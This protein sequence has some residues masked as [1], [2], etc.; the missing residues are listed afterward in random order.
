MAERK[1]DDDY[2]VESV[3]ATVGTHHI[4]LNVVIKKSTHQKFVAFVVDGTL[5]GCS[6]GIPPEK[7]Y[8]LHEWIIIDGQLKHI[9]GISPPVKHGLKQGIQILLENQ[10]L[11]GNERITAMPGQN[12]RIVSARKERLDLVYEMWIF[13]SIM[14]PVCVV[15]VKVFF[16]EI[17]SAIM[18]TEII[19]LLTMLGIA[20]IPT[21]LF[22]LIAL[23]FRRF[24]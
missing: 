13:L 6:P 14:V 17:Y 19:D 7:F 2:D 1:N 24:W 8:V 18:N 16:R 10:H 5:Q 23:V 4:R 20:F 3:S 21:T 15:L 12:N 11:A 9:A 22:Y